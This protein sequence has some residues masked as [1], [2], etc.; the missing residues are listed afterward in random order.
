MSVTASRGHI[1]CQPNTEFANAIAKSAAMTISIRP[2]KR[3]EPGASRRSRYTS[4]GGD[5]L[6]TS[7][8]PTRG[9]RPAINPVKRRNEI[10]T[11]KLYP[12]AIVT[13]RKKAASEPA[14]IARRFETRLMPL[15][16]NRNL[17][18]L[19]PAVEVLPNEAW[20]GARLRSGGTRTPVLNLGPL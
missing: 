2:V 9:N 20:V 10:R 15:T 5:P 11:G 3:M 18:D 12:I 19:R 4:Q 1:A 7:H 8:I 13:A 6:T 16:P 14:M 17:A